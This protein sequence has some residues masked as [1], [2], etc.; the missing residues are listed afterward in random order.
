MAC[1]NEKKKITWEDKFGRKYYCKHARLGLVRFQ[2]KT[3]N[4]TMRRYNKN[5]IE[6][7][8]DN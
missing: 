2:K 1:R 6:K 3:N 4:K 7:S 5:L 8:L